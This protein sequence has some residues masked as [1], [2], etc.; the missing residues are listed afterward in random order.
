[1]PTIP[2]PGKARLSPNVHIELAFADGGVMAQLT[3]VSLM[4]GFI[5]QIGPVYGS[6]KELAVL[7]LIAFL[8]ENE[9]ELSKAAALALQ[10]IGRYALELV[11]YSFHEGIELEMGASELTTSRPGV[12]R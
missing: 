6:R 10:D 8:G 9:T 11:T 12:S 4:G 1:M 7:S 3:E 2:C 5:A